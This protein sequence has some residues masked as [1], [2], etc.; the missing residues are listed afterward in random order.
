[1]W[2]MGT[3]AVRPETPAVIGAFNATVL[4]APGRQRRRTMRTDIAQRKDPSVFTAGQQ[5][6]LAPQHLTAQSERLQRRRKPGHIPEIGE[7]D[8]F[9]GQTRKRPTRRSR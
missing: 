9:F 3:L 1:G 6:R 8:R 4:E 2:D 7:K 5:H